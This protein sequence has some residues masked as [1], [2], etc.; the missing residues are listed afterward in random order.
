[1]EQNE[2]LCVQYVVM[3]NAV[4]YEYILGINAAGIAPKNSLNMC[5]LL[6]GTTD[7]QV[8]EK[9]LVQFEHRGGGFA[10]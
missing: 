4:L 3:C 8:E 10:V 5:T 2:K 9:L 1:M 6:A 7:Q